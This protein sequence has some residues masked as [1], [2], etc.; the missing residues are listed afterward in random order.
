[1]R[2]YL[3]KR[4]AGEAARVDFVELFFDLVFVFAVTQASHTLLSHLNWQG[5]IQAA[6][7]LFAMWWVWIYTAWATNW[8]DPTQPLV[9]V[10]L[11]AMM[12]AGLVFSISIPEAFG[13][14][15]LAFALAYVAMQVGRCLF[16]AWAMRRETPDN[17]T[18]FLRIT[19]WQVFGGLF[20]IGGAFLPTEQRM[21]V[22]AIAVAVEYASPALAFWTPWLGKTALNALD[23]EGAHMAERASAFIIIALGESIVVIGATFGESSFEPITVTAFLVSFIGSVAMWWIYFNNSIPEHHVPAHIDAA[24]VKRT[25][26]LARNAYTYFH[27]AIVAG[28]IVSAVGDELVLAHPTG[29]HADLATVLTIGGGP[30]LYLCGTALFQGSLRQHWP[31]ST[32][33]AIVLLAGLCVVGGNFEPL[34]LA[35]MTAV[36]L[37]GL[38]AWDTVVRERDLGHG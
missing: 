7:V 6:I 32:G 30:L 27:T 14:R 4:R 23:V 21:V 5:A 35:A 10:M 25:S 22:W 15:G 9:R 19:S 29:H 24:T 33:V 17:A 12:L 3:R 38:G 11:F 16:T 28:I 34:A 18:N 8:L 36:V 37:V 2:S 26:D 20:W 1:M 13:E 31:A